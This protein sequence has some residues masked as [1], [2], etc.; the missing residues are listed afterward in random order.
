MVT[1]TVEKCK[2]CPYGCMDGEPCTWEEPELDETEAEWYDAEA[3]DS[4]HQIP[5]RLDVTEVYDEHRRYVER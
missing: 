1:V 5:D 4:F 3:D 2:R